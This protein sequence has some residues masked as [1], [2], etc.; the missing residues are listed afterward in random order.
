VHVE[1]QDVEIALGESVERFLAVG[2]LGDLAPL[3]GQEQPDDLTVDRVVV[4][5]QDAQAA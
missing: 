2:R 4:S 5:Q 3:G 1:Q